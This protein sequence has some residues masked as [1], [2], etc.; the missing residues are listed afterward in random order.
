L[1]S[2]TG[3]GI[4][5]AG[6]A[7]PAIGGLPGREEP[8]RELSELAIPSQLSADCHGRRSRPR[9]LTDHAEP[10]QSR[11]DCPAGKDWQL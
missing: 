5:R 8:A 10:H 3:P 11:A 4:E 6:G 2:R 1:K 7:W 9:G